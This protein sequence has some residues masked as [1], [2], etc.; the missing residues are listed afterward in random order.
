VVMENPNRTDVQGQVGW[1]FNSTET[2]H[3]LC[4]KCKDV[5]AGSKLLQ[6]A[7][8]SDMTGDEWNAEYAANSAKHQEIEQQLNFTHAMEKHRADLEMLQATKDDPDGK[9]TEEAKRIEQILSN[10]NPPTERFQH[11][12]C[13][14]DLRD[15]ITHHGCHFCSILNS[16]VS[17]P[18]DFTNFE[19][20]NRSKD[21]EIW[22]HLTRSPQGVDMEVQFSRDDDVPVRQRECRRILD[23]L[24]VSVELKAGK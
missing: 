1:R 12:L 2:P 23:H 4:P 7:L 20:D 17:H 14:K 6:T 24:N 10:W 19:V 3:L 16:M 9:Y 21:T 15:S 22:I 11:H 13:L 18:S 5:F 8:A